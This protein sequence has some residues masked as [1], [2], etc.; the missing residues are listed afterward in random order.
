VVEGRWSGAKGQSE[1]LLSG[2]GGCEQGW[3]GLKGGPAGA[4]GR[5]LVVKRAGG[6]PEA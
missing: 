5:M 3:G 2:A 6:E 1:A 4:E